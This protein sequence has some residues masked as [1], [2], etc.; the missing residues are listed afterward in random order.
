[1]P[2]S[3]PTRPASAPAESSSKA[4]AAARPRMRGRIV[5]T[6][7]LVMLVVGLLPLA[8]VA[9]KLITISR[10]S[11][12]TSQQEVQLQMA[13]AIA[14]QVDASVDG[15]RAELARLAEGIAALPRTPDG[16]PPVAG[17]W[18]MPT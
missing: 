8:I 15:A 13:S 7:L 16:Q 3:S 5:Y 2:T 4:G 14:R 11:L 17:G 9:R 18:R 10:E 6:F 1:M 12:V